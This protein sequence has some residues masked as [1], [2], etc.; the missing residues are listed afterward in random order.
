M[1]VAVVV[2][3][4]PTVMELESGEYHWCSETFILVH[5]TKKDE[6]LEQLHR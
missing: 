6:V 2:D 1:T 4:K 3:K 5:F